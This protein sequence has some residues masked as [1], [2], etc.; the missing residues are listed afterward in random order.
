MLHDIVIIRTRKGWAWG[1]TGKAELF[2]NNAQGWFFIVERP[3]MN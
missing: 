1:R 3:C 2:I